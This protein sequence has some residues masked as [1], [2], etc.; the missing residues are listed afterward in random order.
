MLPHRRDVLGIPVAGLILFFAFADLMLALPRI[1]LASSAL[2]Y[3]PGVG[4]AMD[5]Q[6][7]ERVVYH[8]VEWL[9]VAVNLALVAL[10]LLNRIARRTVLGVTGRKLA[11]L[12]CL[13]AMLPGLL[14]NQILKEN[15]GRA[16]P[17]Q[18]TEF[19]GERRFT[20]AFVYSDQG[21]GS[22]SSGHAAAAFYLVA[23][24]AVLRGPRSGW[25]IITALYAALVGFARIAAGGHFL[26]DVVTSAFLVLFG[27]LA[28]RRL[29]F[30]NVSA[31]NVPPR[32]AQHRPG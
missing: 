6:H 1:D 21:G 30:R 3:T 8:S 10:W 4:F 32:S 2:F 14:V 26:S 11:L 24:A 29:F 9:M 27:Y 7:W 16:R 31:A 25:V 15:W 17:A 13:L 5:G 28:L 20:P 12:L 19:G 18:V 22:F 23:V